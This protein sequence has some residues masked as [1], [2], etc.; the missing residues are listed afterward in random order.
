MPAEN[1][2]EG[3]ARIIIFFFYKYKRKARHVSG[4]PCTT[5]A[6]TDIY[7]YL[8]NFQFFLLSLLQYGTTET[9][10]GLFYLLY[11]MYIAAMYNN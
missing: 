1:K 6:F 11:Y 10:L 7:A 3:V 5:V 8:F 4:L 9:V 2:G